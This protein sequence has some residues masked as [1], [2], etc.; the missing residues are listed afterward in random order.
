MVIWPGDSGP[1]QVQIYVSNTPD[2]W[3][4]VKDYTCSKEGSSKLVIPGEYL[5]KYLRIKCLN[6]VRGGNIV[7]VRHVL[8][9]GLNRN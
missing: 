7:N 4:L 3:T 1:N 5:A 8:I 9:K 6:N 2:K